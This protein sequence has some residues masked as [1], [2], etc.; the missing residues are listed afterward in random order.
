MTTTPERTWNFG[1]LADVQTQ[2]PWTAEPDK[3]QWVDEATNLDCLILRN[4]GGNLCGY[5]GIPK[6]HPWHGKGYGQCLDGCADEDSCYEHSPEARIRVHGGLTFAAAC[7]EHSGDDAICHV[8]AEGRPDDVWWF[9]FDT[10]HS[11]DLSPKYVD[12]DQPYMRAIYGRDCIYR[13]VAYV[14]AECADLAKQLAEVA[15]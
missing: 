5:V 2:G 6:T 8:P 7:R 13:D 15:S 14:K 11:G 9:G 1:R 12:S 3:L 10:A 4:G